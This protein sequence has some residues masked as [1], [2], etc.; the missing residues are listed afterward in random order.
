MIGVHW[1]IAMACA[2]LVIAPGSAA[3]QGAAGGGPVVQAP[4]PTS[5]WTL[6]D[7][8]RANNGTVTVIT[9]PSVATRRT[10]GIRTVTG[11]PDLPSDS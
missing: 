2:A 7:R 10:L 1:R 3:P 9:A 5:I 4:S 8:N 6:P 11:T